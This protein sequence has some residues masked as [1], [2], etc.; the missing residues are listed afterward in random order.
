M[1]C[2]GVLGTHYHA[3]HVGGMLGGNPVEG[4]AA[5][6]ERIQVPVHVQHDEVPWV[7]RATGVGAEHF[8]AHDSGDLV[9]VGDVPCG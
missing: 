8:V 2:V 6:L 9:T 5:L 4:V 3:D 7:V 1:R